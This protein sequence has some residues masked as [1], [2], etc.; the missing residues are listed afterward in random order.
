[1]A[2]ALILKIAYGYNIRRDGADPLVNLA[3]GFMSTIAEAAAPGAW[4]VD[5]LPARTLSTRS[6]SLRHLTLSM[7]KLIGQVSTEVPSG[8]AS[9]Y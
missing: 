2:G 5:V 1:M 4:L 8:V 3:E 6:L 7:V 9:G